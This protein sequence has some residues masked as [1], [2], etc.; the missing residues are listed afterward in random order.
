MRDSETYLMPLDLT[1]REGFDGQEIFNS[2][3]LSKYVY[4]NIVITPGWQVVP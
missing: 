4:G 2:K 3:T 1:L